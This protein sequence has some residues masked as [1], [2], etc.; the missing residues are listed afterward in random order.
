MTGLLKISTS[1]II[2]QKLDQTSSTP[3]LHFCMY[4][5]T[6]PPKHTCT[7][8]HTRSHTC[9]G[10][11]HGLP[12]SGTWTAS[13]VPVLLLHG[14]LS[15]CRPSQFSAQTHTSGSHPAHCRARCRVRS[16]GVA[17][18]HPCSCTVLSTADSGLGRVTRDR[19][20]VVRGWRSAFP[21]GSSSLKLP[22]HPTAVC[23][24]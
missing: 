1:P 8:T 5:Q 2:V 12:V 6:P 10:T 17:C 19:R 9:T 23:R 16:Q 24:G 11:T 14:E 21:Q 7:R 18:P 20:D 4:V 13:L 22:P 3:L 15:A